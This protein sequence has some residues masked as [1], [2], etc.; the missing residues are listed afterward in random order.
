MLGEATRRRGHVIWESRVVTAKAKARSNAKRAGAA[1][2][3]RK[4][5]QVNGRT[6]RSAMGGG[7]IATV[8]TVQGTSLAAGRGLR[9]GQLGPPYGRAGSSLHTVGRP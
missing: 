3:R 5:R 8:V 1:D 6:V 7:A 4:V 9:N 2:T